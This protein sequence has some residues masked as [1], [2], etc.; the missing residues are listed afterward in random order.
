MKGNISYL[1]GPGAID[2]SLDH[3]ENA[4]IS[5]NLQRCQYYTFASKDNTRKRWQCFNGDRQVEYILNKQN[6]SPHVHLRFSNKVKLCLED[7]SSEEKNQVMHI[8][9]KRKK[10]SSLLQLH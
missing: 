7:D 3:L 4:S 9:H 2:L 8:T 6:I 10:T 1:L 5:I